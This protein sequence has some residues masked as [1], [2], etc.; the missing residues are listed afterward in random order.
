M[1]DG[2]L[3][4]NKGGK[5]YY[6]SE[7]ALP[8]KPVTNPDA[9]KGL[10]K[11]AGGDEV[12]GFGLFTAVTGVPGIATAGGETTVSGPSGGPGFINVGQTA[13]VQVLSWTIP[14]GAS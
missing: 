10:E 7:E 8:A 3:I 11:I 5:F 9:L 12:E 13:G 6:V 4:V 14:A 1:A 2:G